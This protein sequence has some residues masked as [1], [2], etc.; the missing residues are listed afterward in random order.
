M[1]SALEFSYARARGRFP[2]ARSLVSS[3]IRV[4]R[5]ADGAPG[6]DDVF[7]RPARA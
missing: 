6:P 4:F 3:S 1:D 5:F 2:T 7:E